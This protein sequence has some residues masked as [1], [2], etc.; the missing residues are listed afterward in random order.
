MTF[1]LVLAAAATRGLLLTVVAAIVAAVMVPSIIAIDNIVVAN[2]FITFSFLLF[3]TNLFSNASLFIFA[4]VEL[5]RFYSG[6]FPD[7]EIF[8]NS[9]FMRPGIVLTTSG[10][11]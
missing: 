1:G 5:Y 2:F 3:L 9:F 8:V 4:F 10:I 11:S 6:K 7:V